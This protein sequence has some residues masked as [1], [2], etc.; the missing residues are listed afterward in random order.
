MAVL[1]ISATAVQGPGQ[2]IKQEYDT[3]KT[4]AIASDK[5]TVFPDSAGTGS[6]IHANGYKFFVDAEVSEVAL[7]LSSSNE[8]DI[9]DET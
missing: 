1:L 2:N 5:V 7:G 8:Y 9:S 6:E 4:I 3:A